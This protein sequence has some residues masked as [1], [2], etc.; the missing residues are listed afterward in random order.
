MDEGNFWESINM[1]CLWR[2]PI[3]FACEDNRVAV[4]TPSVDRQGYSYIIN[5][6]NGFDISSISEIDN[7]PNDIFE[8][9]IKAIKH[10]DLFRGPIFMK[11]DYYR[12]LEHVGI[13]SDVNEEYRK[14]DGWLP[15][16][17]NDPVLEL[18]KELLSIDI[19]V[20]EIESKISNDVCVALRLAQDGVF[21]DVSEVYKDVFYG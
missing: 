13:N 9:T 17:S 21:S 1:A 2:L 20:K 10:I 5:V 6:M 19:N 3:I 14:K 11:F 12:Y 16:D 15:L 7:C 18:R 4:H 8:N